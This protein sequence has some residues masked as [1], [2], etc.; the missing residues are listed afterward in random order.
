MWHFTPTYP[1]RRTIAPLWVLYLQS[2]SHRL[3]NCTLWDPTDLNGVY[4]TPL[5]LFSFKRLHTRAEPVP[6]RQPWWICMPD[7]RYRLFRIQG[8]GSRLKSD[9]LNASKLS[10]TTISNDWSGINIHSVIC[11]S[12]NREVLL[13]CLLRFNAKKS[14]QRFRQSGTPYL[15]PTIILR[16]CCY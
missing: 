5:T 7:P 1:L 12:E 6:H 8:F 3:D 10:S 4:D 14:Q 11:P 13:R 15:E 16:N 9:N 2:C